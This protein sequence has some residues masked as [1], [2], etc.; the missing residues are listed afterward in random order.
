RLPKPFETTWFANLVE[1][2]LIDMRQNDPRWFEG[3]LSDLWETM[4]P[5]V[6][7]QAVEIPFELIS[8]KSFFTGRDIVPKWKQDR[9]IERQFDEY[10]SEF[11]KWLGPQIGVSPFY[12]D[13]GLKALGTSWGRDFLSLNIPGTPWYDPNKPEKSVDDYFILRRFLWK[14]GKASESGQAVR[15]IMGA[16]DPIRIVCGRIARPDAKLGAS[17]Q[18]YKDYMNADD[19]ASAVDLLGRLTPAERGYA[20]LT[21][22]FTESAAR[23]RMLHPM[24]RAE[25]V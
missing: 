7:P 2:V 22:H 4:L 1:R 9:L 18:T 15:E 17:A 23:Y 12:I 24:N 8:G 11:A 3:Y 10:T 13:H 25:R 16:E 19:P 6:M 14:V 5:P 21:G 20:I